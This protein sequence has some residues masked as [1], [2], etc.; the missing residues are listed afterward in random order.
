MSGPSF[1]QTLM[2]RTYYEGTVPRLVKA[3]ERIADAL[4]E[5]NRRSPPR[6]AAPP[7]E[8]PAPRP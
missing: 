5:Q 7:V 2:G 3:L 8:I 4:E 6:D 1:F